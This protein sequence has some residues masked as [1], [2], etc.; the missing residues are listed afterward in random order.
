MAPA[1][2]E[3]LKGNSRKISRESSISS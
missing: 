3:I 2:S 1:I